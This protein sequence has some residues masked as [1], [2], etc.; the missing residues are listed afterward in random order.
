MAPRIKTNEENLEPAELIAQSIIQVSEAFEK[1]KKSGLSQRAIVL[2][3]HD[4]I[5]ARYKVGQK[6]IEAILE[7]APQLKNHYVKQPIKK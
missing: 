7:Y 3:L 6:Q 2:L 5:P 1:I 4:S